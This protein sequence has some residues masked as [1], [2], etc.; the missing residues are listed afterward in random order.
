M[1][2]YRSPPEIRRVLKPLL[3]L[4]NW[5]GVLAVAEDYAVIGV[6][7][8]LSLLN[9]YFYPLSVLFIGSRQRA[10]T[11]ILHESCHLTLTRNRRLNNC[12]G[13]WFAGCVV[14]QSHDAYRRSHVVRHHAFLGDAKR[15]PD[16]INCIETGLDAVKTPREFVHGF[17]LKTI[18]LG[19]VPSYL[20]YL[21]ANRLAAIS[22]KPSELLGLIVTQ[23]QIFA[24]LQAAGGGFG[25]ILFWLVPFFTS[26]QIIGWLSEIAEHY[27]L[28]QRNHSTLEMTRNR[29]PSWWERLFVGMHGDNYHLTHHLFAGIPFWNLQQAH[30]ILMRD[31]AYRAVNQCSGGIVSAPAGRKSVVRQIIEDIERENDMR[32]ASTAAGPGIATPPD[33]SSHPGSAPSLVPPSSLIEEQRV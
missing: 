11:S 6:A 5:R 31:P 12:L 10:L 8:Y 21:V 4:N 20:K 24:V 7:V 19:N 33:Y 1:H 3:R 2:K 32:I 29:F 28:Y 22:K 15:D 18:L 23:V 14:F 30:A 13:R 26:F 16:Y 9:F 25:Y 17:V 27:R